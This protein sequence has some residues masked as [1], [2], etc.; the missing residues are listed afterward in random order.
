M[1]E[2][3]GKFP[4]GPQRFCVSAGLFDIARI[5]EIEREVK[6][7]VIAFLTS[8]AEHA[9][10]EARFMHQGMTSSDVL[11]TCLSV[12]LTRAA[13]FLLGDL[14]GLLSALKKRAFEH[15]ETLTVGR[16]HGIHAE[17][18]SFGLK[19]AFAYAEFQRA[20]ERLLRA[21]DDIG[22]CA[23]SGA[24]GHSR[25]STGSGNF[26]RGK[27]G[28]KREPV[29]TQVVPATA[30]RVFRDARGGRRAWN[31]SRRRSGTCSGRKSWKRR[32][33]FRRGRKAPRPCRISATRSAEN[34]TGLARMSG[35]AGPPGDRALW[36]ERDFP[37]VRSTHGAPDA[38][39]TLDFALAR[40]TSV[41]EKLVIYPKRMRDNLE[42][43]GG[44]VHSQ[45]VLLALAQKGVSRE[46]AYRIVQRNAMRAFRGEGSFLGFPE[47][48][49]GGVR[50]AVTR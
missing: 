35:Y 21:K 30:T 24:V 22:T 44:L 1:E 27:L 6:H 26:C 33:Y 25:V 11:D 48:R 5:D 43:G 37:I 47:G 40:L 2:P 4:P 42:R 13:D 23:I 31:G 41:I 28:L 7:D 14:D 18:T 34:L 38:T 46:D 49:R 16:S 15:K 10:P 3:W 19:L 50:K 32:S 12:Q 45:Q 17:P 9:G 39:V 29:A 36:H 8:V 20:K